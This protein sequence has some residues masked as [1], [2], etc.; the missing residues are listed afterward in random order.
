MGLDY[1]MSICFYNYKNKHQ[2]TFS[3]L[4]ALSYM[5]Y[6]IRELGCGLPNL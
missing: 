1:I 2:Y 6:H 4:T 3:R 5:I